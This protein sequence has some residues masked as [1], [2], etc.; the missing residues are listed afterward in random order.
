MDVKPVKV[1]LIGS[2]NISYT[3]M[4]TLTTQFKIVDF[5]G[6]SDLIPEKSKARAELFGV[7]QMT[8]EEI[9]GDPEIEIVLNTTEIF[10]HTRVTEMILSAGKH[11]YSEK[12]LGGS[13]EEAKA[14]VDLAASKGLRLGC[15]PDIYLGSAYQTARKLIDDGWIGD[16]ICAQAIC[17]RGY[18]AATRPFLPPE[19]SP[20]GK[21]GS[22]I[23]Y[24]MGGYYINALVALLGPVN[25]ASGYARFYDKHVYENPLNPKYKQPIVP[26]TGA[27]TLMGC[28][29]FEN[30]CYGNLVL[31]AEGF[32]PEIPRVEIFGTKGT[33]VCPDPNCFGGFGNYVYLTRIG[34]EGSFK[35]PFTHAYSDEDPA[36]PAKSGKREPCHNSHRGIAVADM[37]WAIRRGRPHRSSAELALH[38]VEIISAIEENSQTNAGVF[39]MRSRPERP[40]PLAH[41]FFGA[42]A[43]ASLDF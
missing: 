34:N 42:V 31:C 19:D 30:G 23:T 11:A 39:T 36:I 22:T 29:E 43:E 16:P 33:L 1:A 26:S 7:K 3:Y 17:I 6:C 18:G 32:G 24:D 12:S 40:A 13:Y 20:F 25:R 38:T 10:N 8:T 5:V 35:M 4:N 15:A 27:S 37:A 2:G 28:L 21:K 9:L 14:N 41:G